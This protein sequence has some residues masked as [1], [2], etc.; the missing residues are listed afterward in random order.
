[1]CSTPPERRGGGSSRASQDF[2]GL[3]ADSIILTRDG[4]QR[5]GDLGPGARVITRD[6]GLATVSGV[7]HRQVTTRAVRIR[8]GSLGHTRPE[9]DVVLPA[10]QAVLVRD[11]RAPAMFGGRQALVPASRLIDGEFIA[12]IGAREMTLCDVEFDAPHILYVDGLE[13]ASHDNEAAH[14][15]K[16]A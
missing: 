1:M 13:L 7:R 2:S 16:A 14:L 5:V 4:E 10:G 9:R 12:E 6:G 3:A 11:W 8:A 15:S